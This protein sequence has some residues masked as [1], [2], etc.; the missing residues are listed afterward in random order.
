MISRAAELANILP[1]S[2]ANKENPVTKA[3][4]PVIATPALPSSSHCI[5]P[6]LEHTFA[7]I[8]IAEAIIVRLTTERSI[9]FDNPDSNI[10]PEANVNNPVIAA[11]ALPS[12][13]HCICPNLEHTSANISSAEAIKI[14]DVAELSIFLGSIFFIKA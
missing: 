11:P 1:A 4:I 12:C 5:C 10:N 2:P 9:P 8:F 6:N 7:N 3:R 14:R 13:P